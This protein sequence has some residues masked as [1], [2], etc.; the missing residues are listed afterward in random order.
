VQ[1]VLFQRVEWR[2]PGDPQPQITQYN[3]ISAAPPTH[4]REQGELPESP[5]VPKS[6]PPRGAGRESLGRWQSIGFSSRRVQP[7]STD[8]YDAEP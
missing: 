3:K 7:F 2:H 6:P 1:Q 5:R 8:T 4:T